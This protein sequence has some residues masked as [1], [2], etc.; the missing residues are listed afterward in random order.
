MIPVCNPRARTIVSLLFLMFPVPGAVSG[1]DGGPQQ[2]SAETTASEA[3]EREAAKFQAP[4]VQTAAVN[5]VP[6][7]H[8]LLP[9]IEIA[10]HSLEALQSVGD[11]EATL[12]RQERIQG[13]LVRGTVHLRLR[14]KPFSIY[15]KMGE[16]SGGREILYIQGRNSNQMLTR[17][18]S[19]LKSLVGT[20]SMPIDAAEAM[21]DTRY[22]VTHVGM[23]KMLEAII[24]QWKEESRYGEVDVS[25]YPNARLGGKS[26]K[27]IETVHPQPRRQFRFHLTRVYIDSSTRLP[28]RFEQHGFPLMPGGR[29]QLEEEYTYSDIRTNVGLTDR[30]FSTANPAYNF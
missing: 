26:C 9:A 5:E 4:E 30:D 6:G 17:E 8:P 14:E 23:R 25:F 20:V 1:E 19:G 27:V 7:E 11:Y 13:K 10:E 15:L 12:T 21:H 28:I 29:A 2:S 18:G 3:V 16:E 22:P 24:A